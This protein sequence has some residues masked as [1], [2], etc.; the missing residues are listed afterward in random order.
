LRQSRTAP[1]KL[2]W[3]IF[4]RDAIAEEIGRRNEPTGRRFLAYAIGLSCFPVILAF[5]LLI[6][7]HR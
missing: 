3:T 6:R 5:A 7:H 1:I 2:L 4:H